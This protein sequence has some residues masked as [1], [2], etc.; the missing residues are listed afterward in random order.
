MT[1]LPDL[2]V[3]AII[4]YFRTG[5]INLRSSKRTWSPHLDRSWSTPGIGSRTLLGGPSSNDRRSGSSSVI[6][7]ARAAPVFRGTWTASVFSGF[8]TSSVAGTWSSFI[9]RIW[10]A[11]SRYST[12]F[13]GSW[14]DT[15]I[16]V[17]K[18]NWHH[19]SL[20]LLQIPILEI[21]YRF[22]NLA[23]YQRTLQHL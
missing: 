11:S 2:V 20:F 15:L 14:S 12:H 8:G 6:P 10:S 21:F 5:K 17:T 22:G 16:T 18:I 19:F 1:G 23:I 9:G 13:I 7:R 4:I 3:N